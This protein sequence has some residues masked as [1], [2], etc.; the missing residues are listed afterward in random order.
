[1]P[2]ALHKSLV[3]KN[4][5]GLPS[6]VII[7]ERCYHNQFFI[8]MSMMNISKCITTGTSGI[9]STRAILLLN[10]SLNSL[11]SPNEPACAGR[12]RKE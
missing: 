4:W 3:V 5:T 9:K 10:K 12:L 2:R 7:L 6:N 8:A 11:L 1:M